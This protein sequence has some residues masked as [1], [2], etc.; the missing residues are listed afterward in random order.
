MK[1]KLT[2]LMAHA[3]FTKL[4]R[5]QDRLWWGITYHIELN[6]H[7]RSL[8]RA[9]PNAVEKVHMPCSYSDCNSSMKRKLRKGADIQTHTW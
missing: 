8:P 4:I 9:K 3:S 2:M 1:V 5:M 7:G 6:L